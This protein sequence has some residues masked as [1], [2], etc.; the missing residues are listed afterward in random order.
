MMRVGYPL[1]S[2]QRPCPALSAKDF[3]TCQA[4]KSSKNRPNIF[5]FS[6]A[7]LLEK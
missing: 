2:P 7:V 6:T 4:Q 3:A 5:D 1:I